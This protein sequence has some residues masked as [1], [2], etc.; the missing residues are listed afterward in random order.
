MRANDFKRL[1]VSGG[2]VKF[3][4]PWSERVHGVPSEQVVCSSIKTKF[5]MRDGRPTLFRLPEFNFV[6]DK[7]GKPVG[8][9]AHICRRPIAAFGHSEDDLEKLRWTTM[10]GDD[11]R[12]GLIVDR[13]GAGIRLR[14]AFAVRTPR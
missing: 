12:F 14:S 2:G 11:V 3:M 13:R 1:I 6:D 10:A 4:R 8:I 5:E 9:N 7:A